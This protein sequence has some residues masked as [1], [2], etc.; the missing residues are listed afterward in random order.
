MFILIEHFTKQKVKIYRTYLPFMCINEPKISTCYSTWLHGK[1]EMR[2]LLPP[3]ELFTFPCRQKW[4]MKFYFIKASSKN[5]F[6]SFLF[7]LTLPS[8]DYQVFTTI[9]PC[10][11][12]SYFFFVSFNS[13][14]FLSMKD[15]LEEWRKVQ[16]ESTAST[17]HISKN[18]NAITI[19]IHWWNETEKSIYSKIISTLSIFVFI[20]V[21]QI[22][23]KKKWIQIKIVPIVTNI[24]SSK[25]IRSS[26][27]WNEQ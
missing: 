3:R 9:S 18:N 1:H 20:K 19:E 12:S 16:T 24:K 22:V 4:K 15:A 10:S 5:H 8:N 21:S 23:Q 7:Y 6:C 13:T 26:Q 27:Q 14:W 17:L 11:E 25:T 2:F